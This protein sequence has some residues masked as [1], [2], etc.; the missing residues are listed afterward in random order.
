MKY[1][2]FSQTD[3]LWIHS[4]YI[5]L[6]RCASLSWTLI[7]QSSPQ[8]QINIFYDFILSSFI[9]DKLHHI[10]SV[11]ESLN[12]SYARKKSFNSL[13]SSKLAQKDYFWFVFL[14]FLSEKIKN[15][16]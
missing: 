7:P 12:V 9:S 8:K 1:K 2:D 5:S 11:A 13:S 15:E 6:W 4:I 10:R 14:N 3:I 16:V